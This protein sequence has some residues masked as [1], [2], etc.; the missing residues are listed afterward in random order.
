MQKSMKKLLKFSEIQS[1]RLSD[2]NPGRF[3]CNPAWTS[4]C[5][6]PEPGA[7]GPV[8]LGADALTPGLVR[9]SSHDKSLFRRLVLLCI[10][11]DFDD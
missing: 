5:A 4:C 1:G 10:N 9:R 2:E 3:V 7:I 6:Q 8:S 11:A